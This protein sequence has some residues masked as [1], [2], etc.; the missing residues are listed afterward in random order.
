VWCAPDLL[1]GELPVRRKEKEIA[2]M[3]GIEAV[4]ADAQVCRLA[5]CDGDRPYLVPLC[6]GYADGVFYFH[7]AAEGRKME[8]LK[9]NPH[10]CLELEAGFSLKP[11]VKACD[12]GM[13]YRSVIAF[14]R[15]ERIEATDAK[16]RALDL[17]MARYAPGQA[18]YLEAALS[19]T[20]VIQVAA[21]NM[22]GKK[23]G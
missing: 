5:M 13:N 21:E 20:V 2:D 22:T 11:G 18:D 6:F 3:A 9:K 14:G 23:S 8:V 7:C 10:V 16:R 1:S 17:I 4:I 15:A 12:W 19:K